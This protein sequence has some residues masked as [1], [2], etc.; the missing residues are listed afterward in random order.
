MAFN[1]VNKFD[2]AYQD[3][4][5]GNLVDPYE[6]NTNFKTI[7]DNLDDNADKVNENFEMLTDESG[8]NLI[9]SV[10]YIGKTE[11]VSTVAA[12]LEALCSRVFENYT[13]EQIDSILSG[14]V[15]QTVKDVSYDSD[16]GNFTITYADDTEES[17]HRTVIE[18]ELEKM[19]VEVEFRVTE[20]GVF[21]DLTDSRGITTSVSASS[22]MDVYT[23]ADTD[24]IHMSMTD[25]EITAFIKSGSITDTMLSS[26]LIDRL[27]S[28]VDSSYTYSQSATQSASDAAESA[29]SAESYKTVA[30]A[31]ADSA[32]EYLEAVSVSSSEVANNTLITEGYSVGTQHGVEVPATSPYYH[33]N[34]KYYKE[35]AAESAGRDFATHEELTA[36]ATARA[37]ADAVLDAKIDTKQD[38]FYAKYGVTPF[39]TLVDLIDVKSK[40]PLI[41][42]ILLAPGYLNRPLDASVSLVDLDVLGEVEMIEFVGIRANVIYLYTVTSRGWSVSDYSVVFSS[43]VAQTLEVVNL[44]EHIPSSKVLYDTNQTIQ[45]QLTEMESAV[46]GKATTETYNITISSDDWLQYGTNLYIDEIYIDG[47]LED[48]NPVVDIVISD[49][50][51]VDTMKSLNDAWS[52]VLA[53][54]TWENRITAYAE[55][56]IDIDIPIQLKVVR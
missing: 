11:T 5:Y 17:R 47:I 13:A 21:L 23:V 50:E 40:K 7:D 41:P 52:K 27:Q 19:P 32:E 46:D 49:F 35:K 1:Q 20:D 39:E 54:E 42:I 26:E 15:E 14:L 8:A 51:D 6:W 38:V 4:R 48:D 9:G 10:D 37:D 55:E 22:L 31:S 18:T 24:T 30:K 3:K 33:N 28:L 25:G 29:S 16:T 34:A 12:Q 2:I 53:I 36:E 43:C 44:S 56:P 45:T